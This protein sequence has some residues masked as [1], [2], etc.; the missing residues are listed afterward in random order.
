M[1]LHQIGRPNYPEC[2]LYAPEYWQMTASRILARFLHNSCIDDLMKKDVQPMA[3]TLQPP[4]PALKRQLNN[5]HIQ[6][7]ALG[8]AVG[9]GLFLGIAQTIALAGPSVILGY[10]V[11]GLIAFFI[12]RQLG[13]M[14][15]AA[16]V[17]GSFAHFAAKYWGDFAGFLAGWNYWA[18]YVLVSMAELTAIGIYVQYWFPA[19]PTWMSALA[20]FLLINA[21]NLLHVKL[22]AEMEFWFSIIKVAAIV[23]M[24]GFG[25]YL[26]AS[27]TGGA[28]ASV[29]NLWALGGFFPHGFGGLVM[30]MAIIMFS[31]G[32]LELVGIT[33]AEAESPEKT[34]PQRHQPGGLPH[35]D[36]LCGRAGRAAVA[37]PW[38]EVQRGGTPF[39]LVFQSLDSPN[40]AHVL[41][42]VVLTA[43]LSVYNSC[44]YCNSRMVLGLALLGNAPQRFGRVN[45]RGVPVA[46][47]ML[48]A[49]A[50]ATCV[51]VNYLVPKQALEM[52]MML[53]VSA[54]VINWAMISIT[55]L[56][57]R[58]A[59]RA[60][61]TR[62]VFP[63]WGYPLTNYLC[64]AF[65]AGIVAVMVLTPGIRQAVLLIP[66]W[67]GALAV[68]FAVLKRR[69]TPAGAIHPP[70]QRNR[71]RSMNT[72][73]TTQQIAKIPH[74]LL[75]DA[76]ALTLSTLVISFG[77]LLLREAHA[78]T[79]GIS[80]VAF[81]VHYATG[82]RFGVA[83]FL[84]NLPFYY[85]GW[86]RMGKVFVLQDLLLGGPAVAVR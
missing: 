46:A 80:G 60:E 83:L 37:V 50:T 14:V 5:R 16:P 76:L 54:L 19:I 41:N 36:L 49:A 9:T 69:P 71:N 12:M 13:E 29:T 52:L 61:G 7:I 67:I 48:S 43:A 84:L 31:F 74:T 64:L 62:T 55:H 77:L 40:I 63:S 58:R 20:I 70:H 66:V 32:G 53:V 86:K 56:K 51:L 6:L 30:A 10:A 59:L 2:S 75:E 85:F 24:I 44:V 21:V 65:M 39:V 45:R 33:A 18:L 23:S 35:P 57:F 22:F 68:V 79:G 78:V 4:E 11:A 38:N 81:L 26:L 27:G 1:V 42:A 82:M 34:I 73:A 8:G 72:T 47:L 25:S 15:V 17:A 3:N 28:Q